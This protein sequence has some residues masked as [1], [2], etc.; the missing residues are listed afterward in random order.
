MDVFEE[1][2]KVPLLMGLPEADIKWLAEKGRVNKFEEGDT[3]FTK[4]NPIESMRIVLEGKVD[5]HINQGGQW[6]SL[7][8]FE[9]GDL[10]GLLPY[11]RL[12]SA[13]G[14]GIATERSFVYELHKDFFP[15]M[16]REHHDLTALL[17]H[18]MT[19]RVRDFTKQQQ[20]DDKMMALGKLSAGLAHELNNPSAAVVRS[21]H[22]LKKHLSNLPEKFKGVIKIR[23][24]DE[25][26]DLVNDLVFNKIKDYGALNL[27]MMARTEKEDQLADWLDRNKFENSY[28]LAETFTEFGIGVED[29]EK[30]KQS[31]RPEDCIPVIGWVNQVLNTERLVNEIGE[32]SKRI[33]DLVTSIKSYTH[34]DQAQEKTRADIHKGIRNTLT[35]LN[36]KLKK[37]NIKLIEEFSENLPH[38]NIYVS[39]LNQVWTNLIDN[40]ID[41][42][43]GGSA[44]ELKIKSAKDGAFINVS[45][46]DNGPGIP[47][48]IRDKIFDPFYTTK[49]IGKGTGL[50]LDV[51]QQI[52][53]Q[54]NGR[55]YVDSHPGQTE[56]RVC[57]PID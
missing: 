47:D 37:G 57:I 43:E 38:A 40:A 21:A 16:I 32:A 33:N 53:N 1:L 7:G 31:L 55:I 22:E 3:I 52:V 27:S 2:K 36:H 20:Q 19:D 25:V 17:V 54:H 44:N 23:T 30:V 51:V 9:K 6:K 14:E 18:S 34:M 13:L 28:S 42:M 35:M 5:L 56:F 49:A 46:I 4:G 39:E 26:V 10:T 24:T 11:S 8:A 45:V 29:L 12:R 50:G 48:A 15:E 41:A